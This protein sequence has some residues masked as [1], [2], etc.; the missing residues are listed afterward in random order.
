MG[1][2]DY[3]KV[4]LQEISAQELALPIARSGRDKPLKP[5]FAV[6]GT[7]YSRS[8]FSSMLADVAKSSGASYIDVNR[9]MCPESVCSFVD[10][11]G[12]PIYKDSG[13]LRRS[14]VKSNA[15]TWLDGE[16]GMQR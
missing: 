13:H 11:S 1:K 12:A 14:Y 2:D 8:T 3:P 16:L 5:Q 6:D 4:R 7:V 9:F 10:V 15:V